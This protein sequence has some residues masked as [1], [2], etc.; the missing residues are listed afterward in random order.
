MDKGLVFSISQSKHQQL[1][2]PYL[3]RQ[4]MRILRLLDVL[5][6]HE[7]GLENKQYRHIKNFVTG[8]VF[9]QDA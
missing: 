6:S 7:L 2:T 8:K 4:V 3:H 1:S 9:P 5:K